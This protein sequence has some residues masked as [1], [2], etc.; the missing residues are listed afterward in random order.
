MLSY[1]NRFLNTITDNINFVY[2]IY[3][4]CSQN[5]EEL[6]NNELNE[7]KENVLISGPIC[8]KFMQWYITNDIN[9]NTNTEISKIFKDIL[10]D[11]GNHQKY[12]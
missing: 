3:K 10:N 5:L 6:T 11:M 9:I 12:P 2:I 4:I 7:F 1:L 8:I